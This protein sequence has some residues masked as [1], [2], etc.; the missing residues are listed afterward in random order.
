MQ[1]GGSDILVG[2]NDFYSGPRDLG[3][4]DVSSTNTGGQ[5]V[6]FGDRRFR[7]RHGGVRSSGQVHMLVHFLARNH[8]GCVG[9]AFPVVGKG[10]AMLQNSS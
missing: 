5:L 9:V 1:A 10:F 2:A 3:S 4:Q 7:C 6:T 8:T